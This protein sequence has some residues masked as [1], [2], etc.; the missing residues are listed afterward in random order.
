M[1]KRAD[2]S[3]VTTPQPAFD[4]AESRRRVQHPLARLRK[5]I[6]TYVFL[7]GLA[8]AL[9]FL[10]GWFWVGVLLD[11]GTF[12]LF[13]FDWLQELRDVAP[14]GGNA[15][16]VRVVLLAVLVGVLAGLVLTKVA[17]RWI[18]EFNDRALALVLERRFPRELGD[19]LITA[20]ELADPKQAATHG[21]SEVMVEHTIRDAVTRI[22][23]LP[24]A[25]VFNWGRLVTW[26]VL[27][28]LATLGLYLLVGAVVCLVAALSGGPASPYEF[29]W[30]FHDV[31]MIWSERN[32][33]LKDTLWP[34]RAY[35]ELARFQGKAHNPNE[36]RVPRDEQRPEL[37]VRAIEWVV[38]DPDTPDGWRPL[39]WADLGRFITPDLLARV[40]IPAD[41]PHWVVDL[42][43]LAPSVPGGLVPPVLQ[44]KSSGEVR[45]TIAGDPQLKKN[46]A[47]AGADDAIDQL[48]NWQRW[49]VD[50]IALESENPAVR[51][52]LRQTGAFDALAEVFARLDELA[53]SPAMS[54]TLRKL[55]IPEQVMVISR[56][57]TSI[58]SEPCSPHQDGRKFSF[59]LNKLKE[60]SRVRMNGEDYY[61]PSKLITL[62][63]PP[64]LKHLSVDKEE[65][66]YLYHRLQ[67]GEQVPLRG[68]KEVFRDYT[69]SITGALSEIKVP[70]GTN[71]VIRAEADRKLREPVRM[72]PPPGLDKGGSVPDQS[73]L[74]SGDGQSFE[75]AL[76]SVVR[77]LDFIFE[78]NDEDNVRGQRH[79]RILPDDDLP[80][81]F[82]NDVIGLGVTLRKPRARGADAK[83]AQGTAADGYLITPDALVPFVGT[84][85]DDHGLTR[86]GWIYE[87][88]PVDIELIAGK[89][90]KQKLPVL[91][92]EGN[93]QMARARTVLGALQYTPAHGAAR[94]ALPGHLGWVGQIIEADLKRPTS[95]GETF[96]LMD[97]FKRLL[98]RKSVGE[99]PA[100]ALHDKL[101]ATASTRPLPGWELNLR[102]DDGFDVKRLKLKANAA[103]KE[104]QLHFLLK[105][106]ALATDNNVEGGKPF[107]DEQGREFWGNTT[108]SKNTV[109]LLVVSENELLAQIALE[110][111]SLYDQLD[112]A[113]DKLKNAK[114][115]SDDQV[116]KLSGAITDDD[117]SLVAIRLDD[118]RKTIIDTGSTARQ[119]YT[120]YANI[121]KELKVNRVKK[122]RVEK[123][124]DKIVWPLE[125]AVD[126]KDGNFVKTDELFQKAYAAADDDVQANRGAQNK[127]KHLKAVRDAREELAA[128]MTRL[129]G[130]LI[131]MN[132]G[133]AESKLIESLVVMERLQRQNYQTLSLL[134]EQKTQDLLKGLEGDK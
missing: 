53:A 77:T 28:G 41:W 9:L 126:A 76:G 78:F 100:T 7:E 122:E 99:I 92:L 72:K 82:E 113:Y 105:V 1:K 74:L 131:A 45:K 49:S 40:D 47:Q 90:S 97:E 52:P 12:R 68:Q 57:E 8:I 134:R 32:L 79:V 50:K 85:R 120:A 20:V 101:V 30:R 19:R 63:A 2:M 73:I 80:P 5:Y 55:V 6:R 124:E 93:K 114:S 37:Q 91:V 110:E 51:I 75:V 3:T 59:D 24:V 48:L 22:D 39:R 103:Q 54:R 36:M 62:V 11:Y 129:N 125:R 132:E 98:D 21:Y 15:L 27:V 43:D 86:A 17:L 46:I 4:H 104:G 18:R 133:V 102:D 61:T 89:D 119:V 123:V 34:R 38:A 65:P 56:G 25:S 66:A 69:V 42:D 111:E 29:A 88:E 112:R 13:A 35:L 127:D 128:L 107:K 118:I 96:V 16:M 14:D 109:P 95:H 58:V 106:A 81:K 10:A 116:T 33:L 130:I 117:L 64:G 60:T 84:I 31:G 108:R 83:A 87:L 70:V 121:L 44:D 23:R 71:L 67:A 115:L 26:W 94:L